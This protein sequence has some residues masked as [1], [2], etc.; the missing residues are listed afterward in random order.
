VAGGP[1]DHGGIRGG[2]VI[3]GING[4]PVMSTDDMVRKLNGDLTG[5]AIKLKVL[6]AGAVLE[7]TVV[8]AERE[9]R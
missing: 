4:E 6:R 1:A 3:T 2:D 5:R 9:R 8:P 7:M